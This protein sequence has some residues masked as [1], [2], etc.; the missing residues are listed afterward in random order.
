MVAGAGYV[1]LN[2]GFHQTN[3]GAWNSDLAESAKGALDAL[4]VQAY[5][6]CTAVVVTGDSYGGTQTHPVVRYLRAVGTYD[7]SLGANAG[8]RVVGFLGQDSGYTLHWEAPRDADATAYSI[9]MIENLGD[10][11]FPVDSC[12]FDNCG[13]RNRADYHRTAAGSQY[14]LSHCP[15]GGS[16]GSRE[17]ADWDAWVLSAVKTML[18]NQRGVPKFTGYVEP[19]IAVSNACVTASGTSIPRLAGISTRGRVLTG[20]DVMIGGF[21]IGGATPKKVVVRA[22]GPSL[23]VAGALADPVLTLVPSSGPV[24]ANDDWQTAGNAAELAASG[25]APAAAKESAIMA[26]LAPGAYTAIVSGAGNT[27]GVAL[28]EVYE[29]DHPEIPLVGISTRGQ[30]QS[31]DNVMIGGFIIQGSAAQTVVIRARGP[32]LGMAG[33]LADPTLTLV[34][35][36]GPVVTNDDWQTAANAADL[37][38]SGFAPAN[39][40]ESALLIT[41]NP[42]AYTTIVSGVGGTTGIAIVEVYA[43]P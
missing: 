42:G 13:A 43:R 30:A 4:C 8:R 26:S 14:V 40:K 18:H 23:G 21:I 10:G 33:S 17:Y 1:A 27:T 19:S 3:A 37:A 31:G 22:R 29:M 20:D 35:A 36:S 6:D 28:V 12:A 32:S 5:A 11:E 39:A 25:F 34:P 15:A 24:V 7:G 2:I 16:H 41:L 38:A 9:G